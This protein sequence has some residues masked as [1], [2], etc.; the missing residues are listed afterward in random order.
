MA[1][2]I[3][4]NPD[5]CP[6]CGRQGLRTLADIAVMSRWDVTTRAHP[7][8]RGAAKRQVYGILAMMAAL[9]NNAHR[10]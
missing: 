8:K 1:R 3:A 10:L 7:W 5:F 9:P 4:R 6:Y 2:S